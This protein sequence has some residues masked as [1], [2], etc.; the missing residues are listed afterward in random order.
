MEI[1][2]KHRI[3]KMDDFEFYGQIEQGKFCSK[4]KFNL[5]YYDDFDSYFCPKCNSWTK[6]QCSDPNCAC[7]HNR[8][9]TP[10]PHKI[11]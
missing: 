7:C 8:P 9:E 10:L 4:C 6:S 1:V 5:A 3:V 11:V 2:E